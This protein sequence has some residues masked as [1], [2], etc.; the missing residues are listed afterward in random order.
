VEIRKRLGRN[1]RRLREKKELS[2]EQFAF[3]AGIHRTYVSDLE[4]GARNPTILVV[5]KVAKA[6]GVTASELLAD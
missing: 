2:Q 3:E 6:L 5:E 4:R 1:I